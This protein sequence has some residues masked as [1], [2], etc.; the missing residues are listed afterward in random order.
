MP[1]IR[2][3]FSKG[4]TQALLIACL[5][6]P[7]LLNAQE[8]KIK[9][10]EL[11]EGSLTLYYALR[12]ENPDKRYSLHLYS[13]QDSFLQPLKMVSG[14]IGVD[15]SIGENKH[16]TWYY[17]DELGPG[18]DG[19][20]SLEIKGNVYIPF[21]ELKS[22]E[23]YGI[24]K[25]GK[26][27]DFSWSG[28]RGDNVLSFEL[29]KGDQRVKV[30]EERPNVGSTK[31]TIPTD[32]KPGQNYRFRISD[33]RNIDEVVYSKNFEIKRKVPLTYKAIPLLGVGATGAYFLFFRPDSRDNFIDPPPN[34]NR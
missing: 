15:I 22:L 13:S 27:Y 20:M 21:I 5:S 14:D 1:S 28:G 30:F 12:D 31:L 3:N 34:L 2:D 23:A 10:I 9:N 29:Y 17:K 18:Y 4:Y 8:V 32:V 24:L 19:S 16:V 26:A 11:S 6:L 7:F 25:R 33:I